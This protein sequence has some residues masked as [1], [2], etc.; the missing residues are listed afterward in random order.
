M[1]I[2]GKKRGIGKRQNASKAGPKTYTRMCVIKDRRMGIYVY[3][4]APHF[5]LRR[6]WQ[7]FAYTI[8]M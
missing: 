7:P 2:Y 6:K 3:A 8:Y 5:L 1:H 4:H